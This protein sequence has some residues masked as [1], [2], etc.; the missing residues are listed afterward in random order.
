[1]NMCDTHVISVVT[2]QQGKIVSKHIKTLFMETYG[3]LVTS[4]ITSHH[5]KTMLKDILTLFMTTLVI[6]VVTRQHGKEI[7]KHIKTQC[8]EM[9]MFF[10]AFSC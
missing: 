6:S 8:L 5:G 4:V 7:S 2:R 9:E 10:T 3:T 1:M